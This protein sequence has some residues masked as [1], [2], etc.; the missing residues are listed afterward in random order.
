ML[1]IKASKYKKLS[2]LLDKFEKDKAR[3]GCL[4][5]CERPLQMEHCCQPGVAALSCNLAAVEHCA[6]ADHAACL[7]PVTPCACRSSL[8]RWCASRTG[9]QLA[10]G[11]TEG[12]HQPQH[13]PVAGLLMQVCCTVL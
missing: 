13:V 9:E 12:Q 10:L 1:D 7:A 5:A 2:K 11:C 8:R 4:S 6:L 3:R